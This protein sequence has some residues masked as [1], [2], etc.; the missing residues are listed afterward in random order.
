MPI[1]LSYGIPFVLRTDIVGAPDER[2]SILRIE[3][4]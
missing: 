2:E 1:E 4:V 3:P